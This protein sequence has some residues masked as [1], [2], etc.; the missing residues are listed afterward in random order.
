MVASF[1]MVLTMLEALYKSMEII[2]SNDFS[3]GKIS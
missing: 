2:I 3:I 1:F